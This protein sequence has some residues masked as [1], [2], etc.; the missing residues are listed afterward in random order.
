MTLNNAVPNCNNKLAENGLLRATLLTT[1]LVTVVFSIVSPRFA[2]ND[3]FAILCGLSGKDGFPATPEPSFVSTTLTNALYHLYRVSPTIP[4]YGIMLILTHCVA[5]IAWWALLFRNDLRLGSRILICVPL[6]IFLTLSLLNVTFTATTL[7]IAFGGALNFAASVRGSSE[8]TRSFRSSTLVF[9]STCLL[10][11][12]CWRLTLAVAAVAVAVPAIILAGVECSRVNVRRLLL[13]MFP[14]ALFV[15]LD[16]FLGH[17]VSTSL[18][19]SIAEFQRQRGLFHDYSGSVTVKALDAAGWSSTDYQVFHD[20][21]TVYDDRFNTDS[22]TKYISNT[23]PLASPSFYEFTNI[24]LMRMNSAIGKSSLQMPIFLCAWFG[25]IL[26]G[27]SKADSRSVGDKIYFSQKL[28]DW[29]S[30]LCVLSLIGLLIWFRFVERIY[31]PLFLLVTG[32][33][34]LRFGQR[35]GSHIRFAK[36]QIAR[37]AVFMVCAANAV[38]LVGFGL[39]FTWFHRGFYTQ[40]GIA[41]DLRYAC[42]DYLSERGI[43]GSDVIF[44]PLNP[45]CGFGV[46]YCSPLNELAPWGDCRMMPSGWMVSTQRYR[47]VLEQ[48][49]CQNGFDFLKLLANDSQTFL[50]HVDIGDDDRDS[51]VRVWER[52]LNQEYFATLRL[53]DVH[54]SVVFEKEVTAKRK[55]SILQFRQSAKSD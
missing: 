34:A 41:D 24:A 2:K 51:A 45:V 13:L 6:L 53:R 22:V 40:A 16:L 48:L 55:I 46:E 10:L 7:L 14:F 26:L 17:F 38:F 49:K 30:S 18:D 39:S 23:E 31:I 52:Y 1:V 37:I 44:V 3:D 42:R 32:V 54:L 43:R 50:V 8:G 21:W 36:S 25:V 4:W 9:C 20:L 29:V 12:A 33:L 15:L 19:P 11:G 27:W 28:L 35:R 5:C 47:S